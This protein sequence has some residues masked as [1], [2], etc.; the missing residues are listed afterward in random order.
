ML[1]FARN[2]QGWTPVALHHPGG[3][4]ADYAAVPA[5]A[6][7]HDAESFAQ[8]R[9]FFETHCDRLQN[10]ALFFLTVAVQL[11]E[12]IGNFARPRWI[13]YAEKLDHV[14]GYIHTP[15]G[16]DA[17]R[18]AERNFSG[19]KRPAAELRKFKQRLKAR[20]DRRTQA[21]QSQF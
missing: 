14:P 19:G 3:S 2:H 16:V 9:I 5:L 8:S 4:D 7:D 17:G 10:S 20:I 21:F 11:V 13:F 6:I 18:D 15:G 1:P 12:A